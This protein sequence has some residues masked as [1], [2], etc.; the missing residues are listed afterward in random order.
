MKTGSY[1][2]LPQETYYHRKPRPDWKL[3]ICTIITP[4]LL[5]TTKLSLV[6]TYE[7]SLR[8]SAKEISLVTLVWVQF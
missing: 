4:V 1:V 3:S 6:K 7:S 2:G 8:I 5:Q